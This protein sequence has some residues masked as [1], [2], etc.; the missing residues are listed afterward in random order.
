MMLAVPTM[1]PPLRRPSCSATGSGCARPKRNAR[2]LGI[3][4]PTHSQPLAEL[5]A[6]DLDLCLLGAHGHPPAFPQ[7]RSVYRSR[8]RRRCVRPRRRSHARRQAGAEKAAY[9]RKNAGSSLVLTVLCSVLLSV[10]LMIGVMTYGISSGW[11]DERTEKRGG[12]HLHRRR[13]A[14]RSATSTMTR[15][16]S[17]CRA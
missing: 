9:R 15:S 2:E 4:T 5:P 7:R 1:Y 17:M 8:L 13:Q 11:F 16:R 3:F 10:M 12:I 6:L 14:R